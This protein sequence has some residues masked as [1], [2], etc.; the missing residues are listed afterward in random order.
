MVT[1]AFSRRLRRDAVAEL[2]P[3]RRPVLDVASPLGLDEAV[4]RTAVVR[5]MVRPT[6]RCREGMQR[7]KKQSEMRTRGMTAVLARSNHDAAFRY[8]SSSIH[9]CS[10][11]V[12][13][14]S[15]VYIHGV[16]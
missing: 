7:M 11:I 4:A 8:I 12:S 15:L 1:S 2:L 13:T 9:H 10:Y 14:C 16:F 6:K 5:P 3:V